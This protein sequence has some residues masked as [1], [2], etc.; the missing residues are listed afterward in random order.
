MQV[1]CGHH[2]GKASIT[3][4]EVKVGS[5]VLAHAMLRE[6]LL[7]HMVTLAVQI[8]HMAVIHV[9]A[10][11]EVERSGKRISKLLKSP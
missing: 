3:N 5:F 1:G 6:Q 11:L 2:A 9:L 7:A 4:L 10:I 8:V